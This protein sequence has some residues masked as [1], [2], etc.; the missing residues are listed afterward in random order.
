MLAGDGASGSTCKDYSHCSGSP[1]LPIFLFRPTGGVAGLLLFL[2]LNL[3][4]HKKTTVREQA[5]EFDFLGLLLIVGGIICLLIGFSN[6][7]TK[8]IEI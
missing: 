6:S 8:C 4:P 3:N 2:F 7:Q 5:K 1:D